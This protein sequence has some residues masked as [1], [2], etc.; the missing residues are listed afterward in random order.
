[1]KGNA[2]CSGPAVVSCSVV[3]FLRRRH[4]IDPPGGVVRALSAP[5]LTASPAKL[6][7]WR[8]TLPVLTATSVHSRSPAAQSEHTQNSNGPLFA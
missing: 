1:M 3:T 5:Q 8:R 4:L 7:F 2:S 6:R